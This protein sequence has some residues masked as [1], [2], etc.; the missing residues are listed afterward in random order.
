MRLEFLSYLQI[1][2]IFDFHILLRTGLMYYLFCIAQH[3]IT[4]IFF[5]TNEHKKF[6]LDMFANGYQYYKGQ[7]MKGYFFFAFAFI[8][9]L[10]VPLFFSDAKRQYF[11]M[12]YSELPFHVQE[13][14]VIIRNICKF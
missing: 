6:F 8:S 14:G 11:K 7:N 12:L 4:Q 13:K 10:H 1:D 2:V 5:R 9:W 3:P